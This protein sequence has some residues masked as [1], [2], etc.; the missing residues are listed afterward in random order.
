MQPSVFHYN[1]FL[2][3]IHL[4]HFLKQFVFVKKMNS[5]SFWLCESF[6]L[7]PYPCQ[8]KSSKQG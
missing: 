8:E 5:H 7:L 2:Q 1:H 3:H 6:N 4:T